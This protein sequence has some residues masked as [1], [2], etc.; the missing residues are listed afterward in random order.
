MKLR[1][2]LYYCSRDRR[3]QLNDRLPARVAPGRGYLHLELLVALLLRRANLA[4][5][6]LRGKAQRATRK[7]SRGLLS[8]QEEVFSCT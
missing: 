8:R 3:T 2:I 6:D 7:V 4:G 1:C 5:V